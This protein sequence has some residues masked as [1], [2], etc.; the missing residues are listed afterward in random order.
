MGVPVG[1]MRDERA[2]ELSV[3]I[4]T[5]RR[6]DDVRRC[7]TSLSR[8]TYTN[9]EVL[10]VD[11]GNDS[12]VRELVASLQEE[13]PVA[14]GY[15]SEPRLGLHNARHSGVRA[16]K[17]DILVFSDDDATFSADWLHAYADA[18]K[19]EPEM[20][21]AGGP[22]RPDWGAEPPEWLVRYMGASSTFPILSLMNCG[23]D[24]R[25]GRMAFYGVNM[26]IR[27][28]PL[29]DAG[30]F[31]PD[32]FGSVRLGDGESGLMRT[33][34]RAALP[35]GYVPQAKVYHH[36]PRERMTYAY[37]RQRMAN[38]GSMDAYSRF[39]GNV[40]GTL[41]VLRSAAGIALRNYKYWIQGGLS[42]G[43]S[44]SALDKRLYAVRSLAKFKYTLRLALHPKFR[45]LVACTN[46]WAAGERFA[47]AN[48]NRTN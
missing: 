46:W 23:D 39:R 44:P 31:N 47:G 27:K 14:L 9:F 30:G 17:A 32:S 19:R 1:V 28:K 7:L 16:A 38:Q 41:R 29:I 5:Y 45:A 34:W 3:I 25:M 10:V 43:M 4:P 13:Y 18:F 21:A 24:F 40:P 15:I 33:L 22:I 6:Y 48:E 35:V 37:F 8:Q 20:V 2:I 11:N 42:R 36:I 26:A 12:A